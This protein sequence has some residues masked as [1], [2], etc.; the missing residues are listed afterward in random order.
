MIRFHMALNQL[1]VISRKYSPHLTYNIYFSVYADF[2]H[3]G[4]NH[5]E[6]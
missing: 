3:V 2:K 5:Y 6:P 1:Y 4:Y